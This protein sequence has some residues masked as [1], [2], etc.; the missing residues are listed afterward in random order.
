[1][2]VGDG[3]QFLLPSREK[4][5]RASGPDEGSRGLSANGFTAC[6]IAPR[7]PPG[8]CDPSSDRLSAATFS[9]KGRRLRVS[10]IL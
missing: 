1:M 3:S 7:S 4:M 8:W 9:R 2:R 10:L 6:A 5:A